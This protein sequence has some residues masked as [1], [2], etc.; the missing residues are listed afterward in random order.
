MTGDPAR[1]PS[2]ARVRLPSVDAKVWVECG[3][4]FGDGWFRV[5]SWH[6]RKSSC[7]ACGGT[8]RRQIAAIERSP[9]DR[10]VTAPPIWATSTQEGA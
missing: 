5:E 7:A 4:C 2:S 3:S 9:S 6:R 10:I 1:R 8:G